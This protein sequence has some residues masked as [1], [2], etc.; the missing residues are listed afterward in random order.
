MALDGNSNLQEAMMI[1]G[2][3]KDVVNIVEYFSILFLNYLKIWL[4]KSKSIA[5]Y[6]IV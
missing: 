5:L 1:A 2:N 4:F 6:Y 3:D